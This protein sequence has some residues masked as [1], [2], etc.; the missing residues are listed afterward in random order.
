MNISLHLDNIIYQLQKAGGASIYWQEITSRISKDKQFITT[1]TEGNK[2]SRI[3][4]VFSTSEIF[5]SSHFRTTF[6]GKSKIVSTIYD[7]TYEKSLVES[8]FLGTKLNIWERKQAIQ[9]SDTIICISQNTKDEMLKIY[10]FADAKKIEVIHLGCSF[11]RENIVEDRA[12]E[13]IFSLS[14]RQ[15]QFALYVGTR[16]TYKNFQSALIGF[17]E[18]ELPKN[19]FLLVCTGANFD[20]QEQILINKLGLQN[21]VL[22]VTYATQIEMSY[23]YQ[24]AFV[25]LY[26]SI[27]EGFGLPPL[28]AMSSGSPVIAANISS[29]PEVIGDAGILL[30]DIKDYTSI[31]DSL[32]QLLNEKIRNEYIQKGIKQSRQFTW[33]RCA[34]R[35]MDVYRNLVA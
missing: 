28:E 35:H 3:F 19:N 34:D 31:S 25:L 10:P 9:R 22:T 21:S 16:K 33:D 18:S 26:T 15:Q 14:K 20:E 2:M 30:D 32:N 8:S 23:L 7:L 24:N 29:M 11:N 12:T 27:Y 1:I 6:P 4:P 17:A 5:H 13:R